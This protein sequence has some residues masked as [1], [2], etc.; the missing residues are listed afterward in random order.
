[1]G[2]PAKEEEA[3]A[4]PAEPPY[5]FFAKSKEEC[6]AR[7]ECSPEL[8]KAGLTSDDAAARLQKYGPNMLSEKEKK[9]IWER[10]WHQIANVLVLILIIVAVVSLARCFTVTGVDNI[11]SNAIQ[12]GLII[13]VITYV[14][15]KDCW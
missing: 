12:V 13:F 10:I 15:R 2:K 3:A 5:P 8:E 7:L 1:M 6:F 14:S 9:T 4:A 11:V